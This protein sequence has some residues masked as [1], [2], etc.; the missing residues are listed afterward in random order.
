MKS[1]SI[2]RLRN[3]TLAAAESYRGL[4]YET[5][6]TLITAS[7][8]LLLAKNYAEAYSKKIKTPPVPL[9]TALFPDN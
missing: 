4:D 2:L 3:S 6:Q 5:Y 8:L 7:A 1:K 9:R